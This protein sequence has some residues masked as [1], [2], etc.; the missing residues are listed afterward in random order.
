MIKSK[1][2][3]L[4]NNLGITGILGQTKVIE[5]NF[6]DCNRL[7]LIHPEIRQLGHASGPFAI[8]VTRMQT[9]RTM[10]PPRGISE[11]GLDKHPNL[12]ESYPRL[13]FLTPRFG[14]TDPKR[15]QESLFPKSHSNGND[16]QTTT[17]P[18]PI[19]KNCHDRHPKKSL[20][21]AHNS[22]Q[23]QQNHGR[24]HYPRNRLAGFHGGNLYRASQPQSFDPRR[25]AARWPAHHNLRGENF[26]GFPEGIDG[27]D[28]MDQLRKQAVKFGARVENAY[29]DKVDFSE[30]VKVLYAGDR[31]LEAKTVIIATGAAPG[32]LNI[33]GEVEMFG[34]RESPLAQLVTE[35]FT[36][37]WR[38]LWLAAGL[39]LRRSFVPYEVL[40][41]SNLDP[42][43]ER[44]ACFEN[45]GRPNARPREN[46]P[47][48]GFC[49]QKF[50]RRGREGQRH[51]GKEPKN[52]G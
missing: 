18:R 50:C 42:P 21:F 34:G 1:P 31:K 51:S 49:R 20:L 52:W 29:V 7:W 46:H 6:P 36:V 14:P 15:P 35:P 12:R 28:L 17:S 32:L 33:P 44:I 37:T 26:P 45:H 3:L 25:Q 13:S 2:L 39:G 23:P 4:L 16:C 48:M 24:R 30:P 41:E 10:D 9:G 5:A 8:G 43:E 40:L 27:Y 11:L 38:S 22:I 19:R 47:A